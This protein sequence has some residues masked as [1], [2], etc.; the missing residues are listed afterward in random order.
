MSVALVTGARG[1]AGAWLARALLERGDEVVSLD[2]PRSDRPLSTLSLLGIEANVADRVG[3][4]RDGELLVG[5][6]RQHRVNDVYHLAAET[7]VGA[8]RRSPLRAFETL[9]EADREARAAAAELVGAN[10]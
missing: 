10:A 7:I 6:L 2:R 8:V 4:L 9:Y 3:D 5:I 1:F